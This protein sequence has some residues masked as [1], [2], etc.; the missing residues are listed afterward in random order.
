MRKLRDTGRT[1]GSDACLTAQ[2]IQYAVA[3]IDVRHL[4][5]KAILPEVAIDRQAQMHPL[6]GS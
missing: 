3:T 1:D 4:L 6:I 2:R 5:N